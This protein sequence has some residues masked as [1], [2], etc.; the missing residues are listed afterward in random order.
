MTEIITAGAQKETDRETWSAELT[1]LRNLVDSISAGRVSIEAV[2]ANMKFLNAQAR[3]HKQ[4]LRI[5][6]VNVV[7]KK[8]QI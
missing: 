8:T 1:D 6:G 2:N 3:L 7:S 4:N 5:P